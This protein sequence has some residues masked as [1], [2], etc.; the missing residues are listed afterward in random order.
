[1]T[2]LIGNEWIV[3]DWQRAYSISIGNFPTYAEKMT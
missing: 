2:N 3:R 1:M